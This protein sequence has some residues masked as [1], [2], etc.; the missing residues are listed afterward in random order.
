MDVYMKMNCIKQK[1]KKIFYHSII[2]SVILLILSLSL[3]AYIF[4]INLKDSFLSYLIYLFSAYALIINV[5]WVLQ[6]I[7]NIKKLLD[8]NI[9]FHRYMNEIDF[10]AEISIYTSLGINIFYSIYKAFA[11]LYY[12]SIWFGTVAFYYIILSAERFLL[13]KHIRLKERDYIEEYKKYS[14]CG[15]L[16][17]ILT[18]A[19]NGMSVYMIHDGKVTVY[20]GHIIYAAAGYTFYNFINAIMNIVKY[21]KLNNPIYSANKI[22]A[23]ATAFVSVF[24][25]QTAM[26]AVFGKSAMQQRQMNILTGFVV[27]AIII[28]M[29]VFMIIHGKHSIKEIRQK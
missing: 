20:P 16:L 1:F 24:S 19:L 3:L 27:F 28:I 26:F 15:Y 29:A 18:I 12:H 2:V 13:L 14:F 25:L 8:K 7:G 9:F 22:I 6:K 21:R 5:I 17:L 11:G 4:A 23:L 10:K